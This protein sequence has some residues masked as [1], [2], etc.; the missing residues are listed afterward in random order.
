MSFSFSWVAK[1]IDK[2][3]KFF[4]E[5]FDLTGI[6]T[7]NNTI[8]KNSISS[9]DFHFNLPAVN[10]LEKVINSIRKDQ[11]SKFH[12]ILSMEAANNK[13]DWQ[14]HGVQSVWWTVAHRENCYDNQNIRKSLWFIE[15]NHWQCRWTRSIEEW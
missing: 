7:T 4:R 8:L 3:L 13:S 11:F 15:E 1:Q 9:I 12:K 5:I 14:L 10:E 6:L 2:R